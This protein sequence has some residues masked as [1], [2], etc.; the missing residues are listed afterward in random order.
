MLRDLP[1]RFEAGDPLFDI[2]EPLLDFFDDGEGLFER[3]VA[4]EP[5][6]DRF[7]ALPEREPLPLR[8]DVGDPLPDRDRLELLEPLLD[9]FECFDTAD[10]DLK[11]IKCKQIHS[12][13]LCE[14]TS[15]HCQ[16]ERIHSE[17]LSSCFLIL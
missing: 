15:S 13:A 5:L 16:N 2:G 17:N 6:T 4:G 8:F 11:I 12:N 14:N 7:E 10:P 9:L 1:D 3:F